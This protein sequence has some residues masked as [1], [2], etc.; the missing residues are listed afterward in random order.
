MKPLTKSLIPESLYEWV[1]AI[2]IT[3]FPK[4]YEPEVCNMINRVVKPGW[5]CVD[6]GANVGILSR[7]LAKQAGSSGRVIAFEAFYKNVRLMNRINKLFGYESLIHIENIAISDGSQSKASLFPGRE[8]SNAE[9]NIVGHDIEGNKKEAVLHLSAT[10]LDNYFPAGSVLD[11][12]KIDIE[13]AEALALRGMRRIL[14]ESRPIV[15]VE[16]HN[17]AGWTGRQELFGANYVLY[18]MEGRRLDP[19]KDIQGVFHC[20]AC[21]IEKS[22][23]RIGNK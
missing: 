18:D 4:P 14:R 20:L 10:S 7:I 3:Y 21:P 6:I 12:I 23:D 11:F 19:D 8:S 9:W 17:E 22:I 15:F 16:F 1:K 2:R 13:G 5:V